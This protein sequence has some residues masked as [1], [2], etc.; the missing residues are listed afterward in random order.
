MYK[1]IDRSSFNFI[2]GKKMIMVLEVLGVKVGI[3]SQI[4][5]SRI[6]NS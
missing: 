1:F 6:N 3:A 4:T 2:L 5:K